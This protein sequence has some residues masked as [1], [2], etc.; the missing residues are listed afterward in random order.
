MIGAQKRSYRARRRDSRAAIGMNEGMPADKAA[1]K[2][3]LDVS[4]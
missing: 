4:P 3:W 1:R 2:Q